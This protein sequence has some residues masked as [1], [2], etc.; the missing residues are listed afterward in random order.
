MIRLYLTSILLSSVF[1]LGSL[2]AKT[3]SDRQHNKLSTDIKFNGLKLNGKLL[4]SSESSFTVE[5]EK[6]IVDLIGPRKNF[7]DKIK[8][9]MD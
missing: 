3:I 1:S 7:K 5:N 4:K 9:S 8:R 6:L 2:Q